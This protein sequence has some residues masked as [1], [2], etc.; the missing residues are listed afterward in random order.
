VVQVH[1]LH[2]QLPLHPGQPLHQL[3]T[4][5]AIAVLLLQLPCAVQQQLP[6]ELLLWLHIKLRKAPHQLAKQAR[7]ELIC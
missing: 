4:V 3:S 5:L 7:R 2:G 1:P 6:H